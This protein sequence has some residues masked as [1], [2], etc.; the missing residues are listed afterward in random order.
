MHAERFPP[1]RRASEPWLRRRIDPGQGATEIFAMPRRLTEP[2][3]GGG[4][5]RHAGREFASR[6]ASVG[7]KSAADQQSKA[8]KRTSSAGQTFRGVVSDLEL[9]T[10]LPDDGLHIHIRCRRGMREP[11]D[12]ELAFVLED[13]ALKT[14]SDRSTGDIVEADARAIAR[15]NEDRIL[16][17]IERW[18]ENHGGASLPGA[19]PPRISS[20]DLD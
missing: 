15:K 6:P 14:L 11:A 3:G 12:Q 5:K 18:L 10:Y 8:R 9:I 16:A 1:Q 19:G 17:A 4:D 7:R 20:E 13:E 2:P